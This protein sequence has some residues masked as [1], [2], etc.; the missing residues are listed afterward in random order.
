MTIQT[1]RTLSNPAL[2][3][4]DYDKLFSYNGTFNF[5]V[6]ARGLGKTYG[7]KIKVITKAIRKDEQFIYLRRF[8]DELKGARSTFFADVQQEFPEWDFRING[9]TAEMSPAST[10]DDK[11]RPWQVIGYFVAL[12]QG[13]SKKSVAYPMV[14]TII[15][16]EFIIEKG[17]TQYL[18]NEA[19]VFEN[20][21]MTVDRWKDKTRV[22]F[23]ANAVSI[24]NPYFLKY[25]IRPDEVTEFYT[26]RYNP[27]TGRNFICCHFADSKEFASEVYK[28][29]FG[30]FIQGEEQASYAIESKFKDNHDKL[31]KPKPSTAN[32]RYTL[33]TLYGIFSV[34]VDLDSGPTWYMQES[35][36]KRE[37]IYTLLPERM[38]VD[39]TLLPINDKLLVY[40]RNAFNTG[41][42]Y[43]DSQQT[44]SAFIEIYRK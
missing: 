44:R 39:R 23:L 8:K 10:R 25:K 32:Y 11:K 34:W 2:S 29:A 26:M 37:E 14:T 6:G 3:Y 35:R 1:T 20:F 24:S 36:P 30:H 41:R 13:Q 22:L 9:D 7:A 33:E 5:L 4:Y 15:F 27:L 18:P 31:L 19:H 43:F 28:T 40:L 21:Y 42:A 17:H 12:S 16:D 38:D